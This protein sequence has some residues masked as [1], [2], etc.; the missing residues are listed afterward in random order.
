MWIGLLGPGALAIVAVSWSWRILR[1]PSA[2]GPWPA[3]A[4]SLAM[5]FVLPGE[6]TAVRLVV[7]VL[8]VTTSAKAWMAS[9]GGP[10]DPAMAADLGRF[11]VWF[12][13]PPES[14]WPSVA[15][16]AAR[17]RARGL[18]RLARAGLKLPP[19]AALYLLGAQVPAVH[20]AR[21]VEAF[22]ALWLC[23]LGVSAIA[24]AATATVMLTGVDTDETFDAPPLASSPRDFWGRR[25]N[26]FVHRFVTRFLFLPLGGRRHPA[27][28]TIGVFAC[29]GLMHEY[30]VFACLGRAGAYT[31]A[32]MA[33]FLLHGLAVVVEMALR[34][35]RR[36]R[37]P[38]AAAVVLH[39]AWLTVTGP[40]FFAPVGEIF[41]GW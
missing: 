7:S 3:I 22:W 40:L 15:T 20:D 1:H 16:P 41:V 12:A 26:L 6:W 28:A 4:A 18:R 38:N 24:D 39:T 17:A 33:F 23:W 13:V 27:L 30:F 10:R 19:F 21:L 8:A 35:R 32:M 5:P 36:W 9:H 29:S 2:V 25:W 14:T 37:V 11:A 34:R 31:G